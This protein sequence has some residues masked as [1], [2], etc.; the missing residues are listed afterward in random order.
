MFWDRGQRHQRAAGGYARLATLVKHVPA[1]RPNFVLFLDNG[2][3]LPGTYP[4]VNSQGQALV[5][6]LNRLGIDAITA[7]WEFAYGPATLVRRSQELIYPLLAANNYDV[8]DARRPFAP[9]RVSEVGVLRVGVVGTASNIVDKTMPAHLSAGLR[10]T[11]GRDE[12]ADLVS[13]L[14]TGA[15][16][17]SV[18]RTATAHFSAG[19]I[20]SWSQGGFR[21]SVTTR[22]KWLKRSNHSQ[23]WP[24]WLARSPCR[25][26]VQPVWR[27]SW[28]TCSRPPCR[29]RLGRPWRC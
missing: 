15:T 9:H 2:D 4:T 29:R 28:T 25:S 10:V 22:M 5:A 12:L 7:Y 1:E 24:R 8:S 16:A 3:T 11:Y 14:R 18:S 19:C 17:W 26:T 21:T 6:I 27:P 20:C 13:R 23:R